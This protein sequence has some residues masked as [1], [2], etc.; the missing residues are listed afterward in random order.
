MLSVNMAGGN[1]T[2]Q[3]H[4]KNKFVGFLKKLHIILPHNPGSTLWEPTQEKWKDMAMQKVVRK[5]S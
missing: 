3:S 2:W 4:L 1:V 5:L